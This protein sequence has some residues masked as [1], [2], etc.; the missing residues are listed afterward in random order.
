MKWFSRRLTNRR[1]ELP[2]Y[3]KIMSITISFDDHTFPDSSSFHTQVIVNDRG[4]FIFGKNSFLDNENLV[5][6]H[7]TEYIKQEVKVD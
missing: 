7:E 3:T 6:L 5:F 2:R 1:F 4:T